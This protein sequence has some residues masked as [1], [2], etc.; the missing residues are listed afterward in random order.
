MPCALQEWPPKKVFKVFEQK[1]QECEV[2]ELQAGV[3][4][5]LA[6]LPQPPVLLQPRKAAL[7]HPTLRH[8]LE[9]MQLTAFGNLHPHL[10][11]RYVFGTLR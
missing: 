1:S 8:D 11:A 6:V 9:G 2:N 4:P 5:V 10:L 7:H 3:D